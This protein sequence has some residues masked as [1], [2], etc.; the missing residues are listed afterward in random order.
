MKKFKRKWLICYIILI[1]NTLFMI[2][3]VAINTKSIGILLEVVINC[4][5]KLDMYSDYIQSY[6]KCALTC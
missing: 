4:P 6:R 3:N 2:K 5:K 1:W